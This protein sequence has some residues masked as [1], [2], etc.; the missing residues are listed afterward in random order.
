M[1]RIR[2]LKPDFWLDRKLAR[3][4]TRDERMLYMGMWGQSDEWGRL[5]GDPNVLKGQVF[6]YDD[7]LT[8]DVIAKM[9]DRLI[10][11]KVV[12]RYIVDD[13]PYLFLPKLGKH[14]R[15]EPGKTPSKLP[16]PPLVTA[17]E[18][19][20]SECSVDQSAPKDA[21]EYAAHA[22]QSEIFSDESAAVLDESAL[23]LSSYSSISLSSLSSSS[24]M[25]PAEQSPR[26]DSTGHRPD[27]DALC[28]RLRDRVVANGN[29]APTITRK[30]RTEARLLLD[31]DGVEL[32]KALALID[33]CQADSFWNANIMSMPK[34]REKYDQLRS[35]ALAEHR[36]KGATT[37]QGSTADQRV[38]QAQAAKAAFAARMQ[39]N[40]KALPS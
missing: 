30:W 38:A 14:Q 20:N 8:V 35:K 33:W 11:A 16:E 15:L 32:S 34:F 27:V 22:E 2:N 6:P 29:R 17:L 36:Q 4:L 40:S 37:S 23:L 24:E 25:P 18:T 5:Y 9:L 39:D 28:T 13:D 12:Q 31:K 1:A 19:A 21:E 10:A 3:K 26:E 7:D